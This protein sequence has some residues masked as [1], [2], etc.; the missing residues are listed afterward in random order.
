MMLVILEKKFAYFH[1]INWRKI[2]D[3]VE[4]PYISDSHSVN[5]YSD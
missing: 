5:W 1:D 4:S 3:F 2:A